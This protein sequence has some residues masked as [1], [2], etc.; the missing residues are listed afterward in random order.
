MGRLRPPHR[1]SA[2]HENGECAIDIVHRRA[3]V[4]KG[5]IDIAL[6]PLRS[7]HPRLGPDRLHPVREVTGPEGK[8]KRKA[9]RT[10]VCRPP[11]TP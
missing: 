8:G 1:R 7:P 9:T 2:R 6:D 4:M 5:R 3:T 11:R 10:I